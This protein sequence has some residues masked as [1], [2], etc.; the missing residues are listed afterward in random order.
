MKPFR[1]GMALRGAYLSLHR[2]ANLA[3]QGVG[4]T[5]DQMVVLTVLAEEDGITQRELVQRIH[6]DPNTIAAM[7]KLLEERKLIARRPHATDGRA[8]CIDLTEAGRAMQ[9][10]TEEALEEVHGKLM[11][12]F[13]SREAE[14]LLG[15]LE[16]VAEGLGKPAKTESETEE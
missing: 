9:S 10:K 14:K 16:R 8:R 11:D 5:A 4:V 2:R 13:L 3:L 12:L 1:L 6:S 7:L 15:L